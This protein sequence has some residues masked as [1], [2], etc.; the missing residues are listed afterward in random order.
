M[1]SVFLTRSF[2]IRARA[3][4][5]HVVVARGTGLRTIYPLT[6]FFLFFCQKKQKWNLLLGK[7][8]ETKRLNFSLTHAFN[9]HSSSTNTHNENE[10]IQNK[11]M[12]PPTHDVD[13]DPVARVFDRPELCALIAEHSGLVGAWRPTGVSR[14]FREG[15]R[16]YLS[17]LPRL[18]VSGGV[19]EEDDDDDDDDVGDA[20]K[21][22]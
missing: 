13:W 17:A 7:K 16:A 5:A 9:T 2:T 3:L 21:E 15:S 6:F 10:T 1:R 12:S 20:T 8:K 4:V 14:T 19:K 22:V 18:V 11:S